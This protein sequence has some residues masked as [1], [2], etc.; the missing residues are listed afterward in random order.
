MVRP[1]IPIGAHSVWIGPI[2]CARVHSPHLEGAYIEGIVYILARPRVSDLRIV[3]QVPDSCVEQSTHE[4]ESP[5]PIVDVLNVDVLVSLETAVV[6]R[7][8]DAS[9]GLVEEA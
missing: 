8:R 3:F 2:L 6:V 1:S 9:G 7:E 5:L 4:F